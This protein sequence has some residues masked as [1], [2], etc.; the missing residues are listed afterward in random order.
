MEVRIKHY[1]ISGRVQGVGYRAFARKC[2]SE[3]GLKGWVRNLADGRVEAIVQGEMAK[4]S[5]LE[6]KLRMGP[7]HGRVESLMVTDWS[8]AENFSDFQIRKDGLEPCSIE[9]HH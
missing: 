8:H 9:S 3:L 2:A 6:Q 7:T 1:L 4:L 5:E